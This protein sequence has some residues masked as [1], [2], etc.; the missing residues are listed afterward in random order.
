MVDKFV[1]HMHI[2]AELKGYWLVFYYLAQSLLCVYIVWVHSQCC[3][4]V[5][6]NNSVQLGVG[7]YH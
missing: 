2:T 7:G 4:E 1:V 6:S 5:L 3:L